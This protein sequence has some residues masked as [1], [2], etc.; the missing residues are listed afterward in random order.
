MLSL[1]VTPSIR[2]QVWRKAED[3]MV[4]SSDLGLALSSTQWGRGKTKTVRVMGPAG[5]GWAG[6]GRLV[7][8][9]AGGAGSDG[10]FEH[11]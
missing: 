10:P 3:T 11:T 1:S 4:P 7:R 5:I 2:T 9:V 8:A 6:Q